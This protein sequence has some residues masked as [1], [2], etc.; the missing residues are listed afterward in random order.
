[1]PCFQLEVDVFGLFSV[2]LFSLFF[3]ENLE[4]RVDVIGFLMERCFINGIE[5]LKALFSLIVS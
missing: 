1:L 4:K 3:F 5:F 2:V